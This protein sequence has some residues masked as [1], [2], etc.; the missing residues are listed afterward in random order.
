MNSP[1]FR[2]DRF[3]GPSA[4]FTPYHQQ[5]QS[6]FVE[7]TPSSFDFSTLP[8][9]LDDSYRPPE[10]VFEFPSPPAVRKR[11]KSRSQNTPVAVAVRPPRQ[12]QLDPDS[13]TD[14]E[15]ELYLDHER[16]PSVAL[17]KSTTLR[18]SLRNTDTRLAN[19]KA[20]VFELVLW[21]NAEKSF[22]KKWRKEH[23]FPMP[24]DKRKY[25]TYGIYKANFCYKEALEVP[26]DKDQVRRVMTLAVMNLK[27]YGKGCYDRF[28]THLA[29]AIAAIRSGNLA[30]AEKLV[31]EKDKG[32]I[33][34]KKIVREK[35]AK[36]GIVE[37]LKEM[38]EAGHTIGFVV[39]REGLFEQAAYTPVVLGSIR[40]ALAGQKDI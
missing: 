16:L 20:S 7:S 11:S 38:I 3:H 5:Q 18:Q 10:R 4:R 14:D 2:P 36:I 34:K 17:I 31:G 19:L 25:Y 27:Y 33:V 9:S 37:V 22:L 13:E 26:K 8:P 6:Q 40:A 28:A 39:F 1:Y 23:K 35:K 21:K 24:A 29:K 30:R 32:K 12:L 15:D